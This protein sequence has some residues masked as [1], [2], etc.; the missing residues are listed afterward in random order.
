[1]SKIDISQIV[2]F[3]AL[4]DEIYD[5]EA[6]LNSDMSYSGTKSQIEGPGSSR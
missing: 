5:H 1:M 6:Q 4:M 2:N 3:T